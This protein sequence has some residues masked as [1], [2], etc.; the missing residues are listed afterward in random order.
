MGE[1]EWMAPEKNTK[2]IGDKDH[3]ANP[4]ENESFTMQVRSYFS[5]LVRG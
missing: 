1:V 3:P 5:G 4:E 2:R